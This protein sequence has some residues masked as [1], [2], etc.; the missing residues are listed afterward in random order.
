MND[1]R[2]TAYLKA[3][4]EACLGI[5]EAR[6]RNFDILLEYSQAHG[7]FH[8]NPVEKKTWMGRNE[9]SPFY[10]P[11]GYTDSEDYHHFMD[12]CECRGM[13]FLRAIGVKAPSY[14][15]VAT[16]FKEYRNGIK[17]GTVDVDGVEVQT[18]KREFTS[19]NIIEVEVGT[20]GYCG[21]DSGHGGRTYFRI[22]DLSSTDMAVKVSGTSCGETGKVEIM[23]GGDSELETFIDALEFAA[24]TLREQ[25]GR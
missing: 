25:A 3:L 21:G 6:E 24:E 5:E 14:E 1:E 16:A 9:P 22:E 11:L 15:E 8:F 17:H 12:F 20:T 19:A 2:L 10:V 4:K 7:M 23:F 13:E 18:V